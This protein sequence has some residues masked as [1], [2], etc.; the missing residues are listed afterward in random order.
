MDKA[1]SNNPINTLKNTEHHEQA[2]EEDVRK[3]HEVWSTKCLV[4]S[5]PSNRSVVKME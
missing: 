5:P 1:E 4:H 3:K 2:R